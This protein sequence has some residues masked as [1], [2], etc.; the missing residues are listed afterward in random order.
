MLGESCSELRDRLEDHYEEGRTDQKCSTTN[1]RERKHPRSCF[2]HRR[3]IVYSTNP[4][5]TSILLCVLQCRKW[6][7]NL[8]MFRSLMSLMRICLVLEAGHEASVAS[9]RHRQQQAK[10]SIAGLGSSFSLALRTG[11]QLFVLAITV[12]LKRRAPDFAADLQRS[13]GEACDP[14]FRRSSDDG[15]RL[16]ADLGW[17]LPCI[18]RR[19]PS[20]RATVARSS[21]S[22]DSTTHDVTRP[23]TELCSNL[24]KSF[25]SEAEAWGV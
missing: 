8:R 13:L 7:L 1:C 9:S 11:L 15:S 4:G 14:K 12:T 5:L 21:R 2:G 18:A 19:C 23:S 25:G 20:G 10:R 24:T 16:P 3:G 22:V 17:F 6:S